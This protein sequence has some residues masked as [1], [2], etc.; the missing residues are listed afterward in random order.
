ML[1]LALKQ[2]KQE[3]A[4]GEMETNRHI[5]TCFSRVVPV[6]QRK[7]QLFPLLCFRG[8][9]GLSGELSSLLLSIGPV[10]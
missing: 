2:E 1:P 10:Q 8:S 3:L 6:P 4:E 9:A 7:A 5:W